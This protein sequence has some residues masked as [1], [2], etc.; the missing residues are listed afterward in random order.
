M[1]DGTVLYHIKGIDSYFDPANDL[2]V[3]TSNI[4]NAFSWFDN[5]HREWNLRVSTLWFVYDIARERWYTKDTGAAEM[6]ACA[7]PVNST[8]GNQYNY[9][10]TS[11]GYMMRLENGYSWSTVQI[12]HVIETGDF[13]P[14]KNPWDITMIDRFKYVGVKDTDTGNI[15]VTHYMDG[16]DSGPTTVD[17]IARTSGSARY[18]RDTSSQNLLGLSYRFRFAATSNDAAGTTD[19]RFKPLGWGVQWSKQR[20]DR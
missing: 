19:R 4:E 18:F 13:W 20:D 17:T 11:D 15:V 1:T 16:A 6:P 2:Y 7:F 8:D 5:L 3:G 12:D 10:G 14:S 9:A